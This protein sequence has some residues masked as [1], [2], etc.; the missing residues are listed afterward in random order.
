MG[1]PVRRMAA[2]REGPRAMA[3]DD[4]FDLDDLAAAAARA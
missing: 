4:A 3:M 2:R 1:P